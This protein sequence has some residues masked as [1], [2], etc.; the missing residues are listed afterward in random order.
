[1]EL[2]EKTSALKPAARLLA[3]AVA[4]ALVLFAACC[5]VAP[6]C[7]Y[8]SQEDGLSSRA[9]GIAYDNSGSMVYSKSTKW[10]GAKYSLE[11]IAAMLDENDVMALY[12]MDESSQKLS[13]SGD[14]D[15]AERVR[16]IHDADL[17][18][19][20]ETDPAAAEN[21]LAYLKGVPA[22]E[23]FLIITTDGDFTVGKKFDG[24]KEVVKEAKGLGISV[25]YL[26]IGKVNNVIDADPSNGVF[27]KLASS[28]E[29][30]LST[31]VDIANQ[32]FGRDAL[33]GSSVDVGAGRFTFDVPMSQLIVFAQ[34]ENVKVGN[35]TTDDGRE[36]VGETSQVRYSDYAT[37]KNTNYGEG[38][39]DRTLQGVICTF[40][41]E[42]PK[43]SAQASVEGASNVEVYYTPYVG[44]AADLVEKRT[45]ISYELKPGEQNELSAGEYEADLRFVDPFTGETIVS[46]LLKD[47]VFEMQCEQDGSVQTVAPGETLMVT[48][49]EVSLVAS[50]TTNGSVRVTQDYRGINVSPAVSPMNMDASAI[51][52]AIPIPSFG[53]QS[54]PVKLWKSDGSAFSPGEWSDLEFEITDESG[55]EWAVEKS[56]QPGT[57]N[58]TPL[59]I[60]GD[61][62]ATEQ[63]L[64]GIAPVEANNTTVHLT[65]QVVVGNDAFRANENREIAYTGDWLNFFKHTWP[66]LLALLILLYLIYKYLTKPRLP[67]K[68]KPHL[69]IASQDEPVALGYN[70]ANIAN[71][72]SPWGPETITFNARSPKDPIDAQSLRLTERYELSRIGLVA[73]KKEGGKRRF[74][75][76][77][78]TLSDMRRHIKEAQEREENRI[79]GFPDPDYNPKPA[80][81]FKEQK[82]SRGVGSTL[83]FVGYNIPP[84]GKK[85]QE[86]TYTIYFKKPQ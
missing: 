61:E 78:Q 24:V 43:G 76:D 47:P 71:K 69:V 27:V 38:E 23:K 82:S 17:N 31:M 8:A 40:K 44:I 64:L 11:V 1:M 79:A 45:G 62:W 6:R 55:V 20:E 80:K 48:P 32:V 54:Y 73:C 46:D 52:N 39:P 19:S 72:L 28:S 49:G 22:D 51:P 83:T 13:I 56:E 26:A 37:K 57:V 65:A 58:V 86:E 36:I 30:I 34:G 25:I 84:R 9:I 75:F 59:W 81:S 2:L 35:L 67:R 74:K 16:M 29:T 7:A 50:A 4:C 53:E 5:A 77:E 70:E 42:I 12:A 66:F 10:C 21:A 63:K 68:M 60:D 33:P 18:V 3:A 15:M 85:K 14:Q 41:G